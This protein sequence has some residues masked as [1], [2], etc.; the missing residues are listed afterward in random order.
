MEMDRMWGGMDGPCKHLDESAISKLKNPFPEINRTSADTENAIV[1]DIFFFFLCV[2][3]GRT[4]IFSH[5]L[6][7]LVLTPTI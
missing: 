1:I 6:S 3:L 7:R 2:G 4:L 5:I